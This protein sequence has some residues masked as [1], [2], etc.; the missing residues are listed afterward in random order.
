MTVLPAKAP[1]HQ[2][3]VIAIPTRQNISAP[4]G[5]L[6]YTLWGRKMIRPC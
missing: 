5:I 1:S 6:A 4:S 2:S 3:P